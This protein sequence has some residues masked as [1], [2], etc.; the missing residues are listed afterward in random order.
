MLATLLLLVACGGGSTPAP[1][2]PTPPPAA[3][4]ATPPAPPP[5]AAVGP[6]G[7]ESIAISPIA[8][9]STDPAVIAEGEAVFGTKGCGACHKF[10]EKLVGPDLKGVT[11]R[12]TVPW[13]QRMIAEPEIMTK[14]DPVAKDMYRTLMVQMSKQGVSADEMPKLVAFLKSKEN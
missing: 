2:T 9:V 6:D 12:R 11:A 5:A 10:G 7:P 14:Q 13:I 4:P 8:A 1:S 3:A